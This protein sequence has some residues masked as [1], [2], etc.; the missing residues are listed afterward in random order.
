MHVKKYLILILI[1]AH[2]THPYHVSPPLDGCQ[3]TLKIE[4]RERTEAERQQ[5][6]LKLPWQL[7]EGKQSSCQMIHITIVFVENP[8]VTPLTIW[9][10]KQECQGIILF[11][12]CFI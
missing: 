3:Q 2:T 8:A 11:H 7:V 9:P 6:I 5:S 12:S 1:Y 4:Q 10:K